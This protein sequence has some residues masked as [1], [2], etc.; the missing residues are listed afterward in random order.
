MRKPG[1][2]ADL[3]D[4]A[5]LAVQLADGYAAEANAQPSPE[6]VLEEM[7]V[8]DGKAAGAMHKQM[9]AELSAGE[10]GPCAG[11]VSGSAAF[12][13]AGP[14]ATIHLAEPDDALAHGIGSTAESL[15]ERCCRFPPPARITTVV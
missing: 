12:L 8:D 1:A 2:I 11:A 7:R 14:R 6:G 10:G 9:L 3:Q 4:I 5:R 13:S 15:L